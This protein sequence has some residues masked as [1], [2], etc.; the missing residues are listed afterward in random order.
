MTGM[1]GSAPLAI[2]AIVLIAGAVAASPAL[3]GLRGL[4][5]DTLTALRWRTMG[6]MHSA[7]ESPTVVISL[8]QTTYQTPPFKGT[9]TVAWTREI[10]RVVT[11]VL[12]GG[13]K[14]VGFD[15]IF[16]SSIE[17]SELPF[18]T[19]TIGSRLQGFDRDFLRA[20]ALGA[21]AGKV[22]L[23]EV[24]QGDKFVLPAPGQRAAVG[25]QR[26]IRSLNVYSG[27]DG[28]VRRMPLLFLAD[29][30]SI[31]SMS[32]E[33]A[34]RALGV[35]PRVDADG[36]LTLGEYRIPI[37]APNAM[38]LNFDGGSDDI[39]TYSFADL[40]ACLEKGDADFFHRNFEGK[41]VLLGSQ[42]D[43]EDSKTTT[44][45]FVPAPPVRSGAR[46]ALPDEAATPIVRNSTDGVYVHATAI[47]DLIRHEVVAEVGPVPRWLIATTGA[48]WG[49]I[50]ALLLTPAWAFLSYLSLGLAWT[51]GA[52]VA[53]SDALALPLVE[54]LL[55]GLMALIVT[56]GLRLFV[57]DRD[58]RFLR[59]AFELY[60][61][62]QVV[63]RILN[64]S[65]PPALGGETRNVTMFFSDVSG[66]SA[67]SEKMKPTDLVSMLNRYLSAMT[68]IIERR[69]GFVDKYIGDAI[70]AIFGAPVEESDHAARAVRAALE[71]SSEL[72]RLNLGAA[73]PGAPVLAHRIG[74]N[75][76]PA[77]LGNIGSRR[78][79]N[80]TVVGDAVNLASR[81]EGANKFFGTSI[82]ASESTM[83]L[84]FDSFVWREVDA[85][86][87]KG[88]VE[89]IRVFEP[90]CE[91][92]RQSPEQLARTS[93]YTE[94]L[95]R[96]RARDFAGAARAFAVSADADAP[97][98]LYLARAKLLMENPPAE[99]W[100]P[101]QT[102]A[103]K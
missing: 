18:G 92:G 88:R 89:P 11:G 78:R 59:R 91:A 67:L 15:V 62:P 97:S 2:A 24:Q 38:T 76:G 56:T 101:V 79:F 82:L 37:S 68:E 41:V 98:A 27:S 93:S 26:N 60:L 46:C 87:V 48:G 39:P 3:D 96:W 29:K 7:S 69:G 22:V 42:L 51:A 95:A 80:Y 75:S 55:A 23:G 84:A 4:S 63:E 31:P 81:L 5:L 45:R 20:L 36:S 43:F 25:Q 1:R 12:D 33:L 53:F 94:G 50:A 70:V 54:P 16:P 85:I 102:L 14:V 65:K 100:R 64:S 8:D 47:N 99:N 74:L 35:A 103:D 9:P 61:A 40:H 10:G 73:A 21:R 71:C 28:V 32:L 52:T 58:R 90:I 30:K 6:A 19:E 77:V 83:K 13:A 72:E 49:A 66:F 44:N 34:S 86:C 17:E 57:S